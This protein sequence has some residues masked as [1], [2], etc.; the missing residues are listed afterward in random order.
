MQSPQKPPGTG[1]AADSKLP[2]GWAVLAALA[3]TALAALGI[4]WWVEQRSSAEARPAPEELR[5]RLDINRAS[6]R[7]LELLPGIGARRA[8]RIIK[9]RQ[10]RGGF[11]RLAELDEADVLGPGAAERL[12][13]YLLPLPKESGQ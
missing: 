13:P 12:A 4:F 6:A 2:V 9:A 3:L 10:Q 8:M 5:L 7:E 11:K 1:P